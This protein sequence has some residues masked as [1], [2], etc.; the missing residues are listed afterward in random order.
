MLTGIGPGHLADIDVAMAIDTDAVWR[1][2][3]ARSLPRRFV[4]QSRQQ[5]AFGVVNAHSRAELAGLR[6][7]PNRRANAVDV[8]NAQAAPQDDQRRMLPK[9]PARREVPRL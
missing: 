6:I 3:L 4:A 9:R 8:E 1:D 5:L 2:E 7:R